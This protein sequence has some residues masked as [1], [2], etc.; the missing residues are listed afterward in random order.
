M[1]FCS[2]FKISNYLVVK[3]QNDGDRFCIS[4]LTLTLHASVSSLVERNDYKQCFSIYP[5]DE[6]EI[7]LFHQ[8]IIKLTCLILTL[9]RSFILKGIKNDSV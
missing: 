1:V 3:F 8:C 2:S 7:L 5:T 4:V 6:K 9:A